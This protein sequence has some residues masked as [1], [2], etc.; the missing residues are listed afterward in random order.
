MIVVLSCPRMGTTFYCEKVAKE[1]NYEC[2]YEYFQ[3]HYYT[4][5]L[6]R[7][8]DSIDKVWKSKGKYLDRNS[9]NVFKIFPFQIWHGPDKNLLSKLSTIPNVEFHFLVRKNLYKSIESNYI[10]NITNV[11][12]ADH[13][14]E[15]IIK[16]DKKAIDTTIQSYFSMVK[17]L[18][19]WMKELNDKGITV[20]VIFAESFFNDK[21]K[22][23]RNIIFEKPLNI[24]KYEIDNELNIRL[25]NNLIENAIIKNINQVESFEFLRK[26]YISN[27]EISKLMTKENRE[28][29]NKFRN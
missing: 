9:N 18:Q 5:N 1:K 27:E 14:I 11:P 13:S 16:Y 24:P 28:F 17:Q 23:K 2:L 6:D 29:Y 4:D 7:I 20:K 22:Q 25:N 3:D 10:T 21:D 12:Y 19:E 15:Y 8:N 26:E